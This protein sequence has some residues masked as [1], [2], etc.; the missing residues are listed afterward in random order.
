M[1]GWHHESREVYNLPGPWQ[2]GLSRGRIQK[3]TG[4]VTLPTSS[5]LLPGDKHILTL[6]ASQSTGCLKVTVILWGQWRQHRVAHRLW[7]ETA[8]IESSSTKHQ[9]SDLGQAAQL[10]GPRSP[11]LSDWAAND[12]SFPGCIRWAASQLRWR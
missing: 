10:P 12:T 11:H 3:G 8:W 4:T 7:R 1:S 6:S 9:L 5:K 2:T